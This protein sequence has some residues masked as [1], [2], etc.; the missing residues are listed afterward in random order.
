MLN[1]ASSTFRKLEKMFE[2]NR[3]DFGLE[4]GATVL[5]IRNFDAAY[6]TDAP[7]L[8]YTVSTLTGLGLQCC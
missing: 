2:V 7:A 6:W 4:A 3:L 8:R 5:D 1:K